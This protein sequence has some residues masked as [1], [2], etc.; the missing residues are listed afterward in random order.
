MSAFA[1]SRQLPYPVTRIDIGHTA[2]RLVRTAYYS[3]K[4]QREDYEAR[5]QNGKTND[6]RAQRKVRS[7]LAVHGNIG[8]HKRCD[9]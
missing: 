3:T 6:A 4:H 1:N 7:T 5:R 8:E 2:Q 9:I